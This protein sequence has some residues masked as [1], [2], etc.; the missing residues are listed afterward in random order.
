MNEKKRLKEAVSDLDARRGVL[1]D[2][3]VDTALGPLRRRL[4]ELAHLERSS[5][6]SPAAERKV[7]TVMFADISGYT[8]FAGQQDPEALRELMNACFSRLVSIVEKYQG[9]LDKFIGDQI[10][11]LFGAPVAHEKAPEA[12]LRAALEMMEALRAFNADHDVDLG[13]HIGINTGLVIAGAIG[14]EGREQYSVMGD[15]VNVGA[16]LEDAS[17]RG[18]ILVGP[19]TYRLTRELFDFEALEPVSVQGKSE[20]IPV[21]ELLGTKHGPRTS[22]DAESLR[23]PLVGR[24]AELGQ[25]RAAI[26]RLHAGEGGVISITG[27]AGLGKSRL[28]AEA[29][30]HNQ[31][32]IAWAEGRGL[33]YAEDTSYS[34]ARDV[35]YSLLNT[36]YETSP[37]DMRSVLRE[38]VH[39]LL[40]GDHG[41]VYPYLAYL[42]DIPPDDDAEQAVQEV[43]PE[44]LQGRILSSFMEYVRA[45]SLAEPLVLVGE[46]LHWGDPSSLR[47]LRAL[48]NITAEA[49][50]LVLLVFRHEG[51]RIAAFEERVSEARGYRYETLELT[52]L[53]RTASE[54]LIRNLLHIENLPPRISDLILDKAEGNPFFMEEVLRS[55]VDAGLVVLESNRAIATSAIEDIEVPDTVQGVVAARIDRLPLE[56]KRT[57]QTASVI[58][59]VFQRRVLAYMAEQESADYPLER[60]LRALL[61][62]ELIRLREMASRHDLPDQEYVFKHVITRDVTYYSLLLAR[63]RELHRVAAEAIEALFSDRLDELAATLA[64]HCEQADLREKA[65]SYL[66]VAGERAVRVCAYHEAIAHLSRALDLLDSLPENSRR[67]RRKLAI[68]LLLAIP[69]AAIEGYGAQ[70]VVDVLEQARQLAENV[71]SPEQLHHTLVLLSSLRTMR[72]SPGFCEPA[73][74]SLEVARKMDDDARI[75]TSHGGLGFALLHTGDFSRARTNFDEAIAFLTPMSD[76][77]LPS[78]WGFDELVWNLQWRAWTLWFLG[79]P[80]QALEEGQKAVA[81]TEGLDHPHSVATALGFGG[82]G[83]A[84]L[85]REPNRARPYLERVVRLS[86]QE[87]LGAYQV[88]TMAMEGWLR[89]EKGQM[90]DG[91]VQLR[92]GLNAMDSIGV[93]SLNTCFYGLLAEKCCQAHKI[94]DGFS[95]V[96]EGLTR[97][98]RSGEEIYAAELNRVR[99]ELLIVT[100]AADEAE[101]AL[102]K[103]LEIARG[104]GAKSLELRAAVSLSRVMKTSGDRDEAREHLQPVYDWFTEGFDTPDLQ[105]ARALLEEL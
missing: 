99:G 28:V 95:A 8:L 40:P 79:Y 51:E 48:F 19:D 18:Q 39:R 17:S 69:H 56:D 89:A 23:S 80:D 22:L 65:A 20:K 4:S 92:A 72:A 93:R 24:D 3:V 101:G 53:S 10:M 44:A 7:V 34:V 33:S 46:D 16:R 47:L 54:C 64:H 90:A 49:P 76:G 66:H 9:T 55:M 67:S 75:T 57:L 52:P 27:D 83:I 60:S 11:A 42:L 91:I 68:L 59:R 94:E 36:D 2:A 58:G 87:H 6:H 45:R 5:P 74:A 100:D 77:P 73:E 1:G 84:M 13:M 26:E 81:R 61:R 50:L 102:R 98:R 30:E 70:A 21:Y 71:G 103:A 85:R 32:D 88:L 25:L 104:Q 31:D 78:L 15:A 86:S 82:V 12:S 29:R 97:C 38:S 62:R 96:A 63:R 35:C 14:S 37:E 105:E 41:E 43:A